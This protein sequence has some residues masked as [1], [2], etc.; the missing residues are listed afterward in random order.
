MFYSEFWVKTYHKCN[1]GNLRSSRT[2]LYTSKEVGLEGNAEKTTCLV[3]FG[4]QTAGQDP[5]FMKYS[6]SFEKVAKFIYL[7]RTITYKN[8]FHEEIKTTLTSGIACHLAVR[9]LRIKIKKHNFTCC[10]AWVWNLLY[11]TNRGA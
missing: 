9:N 5:N 11:H 4:R 8:C 6:K 2:F 7:R 10:F 1:E 3:M